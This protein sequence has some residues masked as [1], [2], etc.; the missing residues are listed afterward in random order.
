MHH[1]ILGVV[2]LKLVFLGVVLQEKSTLG[3]TPK[4]WPY[5]SD[6]IFCMYMS[7]VPTTVL[8]GKGGVAFLAE[9]GCAGDT[10]QIGASAAAYVI[11]VT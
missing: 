4:N 10:H 9:R 1:V 7:G 11:H 6:G 2:L 5:L 8:L 3:I